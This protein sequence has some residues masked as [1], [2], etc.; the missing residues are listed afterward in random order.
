MLGQMEKKDLFADEVRLV[1]TDITAAFKS[2]ENP[3]FNDIYQR[4]KK[5][6]LKKW[7]EENKLVAE[8]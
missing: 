2:E 5:L 3:F 1:K 4:A 8:E 7:S 6:A